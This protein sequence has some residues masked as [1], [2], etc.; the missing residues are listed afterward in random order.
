V[1]E[2]F[3]CDLPEKSK[4]YTVQWK[5]LHPEAV[6]CHD[7]LEPTGFIMECKMLLGIKQ[8]AEKAHGKE[9]LNALQHVEQIRRQKRSLCDWASGTALYRA[10]LEL[11]YKANERRQRM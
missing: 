7:P 10:I 8:R 2:V 1:N 5:G 11:Q 9:I 6:V 3:E 4:D